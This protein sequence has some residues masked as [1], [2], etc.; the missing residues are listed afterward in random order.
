MN[1]EF[2]DFCYAVNNKNPEFSHEVLYVFNKEYELDR[3]GELVSVD[4]YIKTNKTQ[5]RNGEEFMVI[6]SFHERNMP[7]KFLFR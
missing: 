3:W 4:I 7:L 6:V 1:L 5:T 2:D